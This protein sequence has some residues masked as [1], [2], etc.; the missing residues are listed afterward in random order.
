MLTDF[1]ADMDVAS[2]LESGES[3]FEQVYSNKNRY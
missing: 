1:S 3:S 2:E